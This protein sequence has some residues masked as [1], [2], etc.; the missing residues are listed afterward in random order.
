MKPI[1]IVGAGIAGLSAA[2]VLAE[3]GI[4][5]VVFDKSRAVGGRMATR[6]GDD[7][8]FDHGAQYF[9][10][11]THEFRDEIAAWERAGVAAAWAEDRFVGV[12]DM[13]APARALS[14]GLSVVFN[15]TVSALKRADGAWALDALEGLVAQ[16][17]GG[18][19]G[20]VLAMPAPQVA[21]VLAA[22]GLELPGVE[23]ATYAPCWALMVACETPIAGLESTLRPASDMIAWVATN[24]AKP[25]RASTPA[26][27]V[28][29]ARAAWTQ[30]NLELD[31]EAARDALLA[32]F[33]AVTGATL[34]GC[35][36]MAHRWRYALVE[37]AVGQPFLFDAQAGVGACGDWC[38]G[39]RV[40][41]AWLS[42][43]AMG[44]RLVI[45]A[46]V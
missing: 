16:P 18:F 20:V 14:N 10:A 7:S 38:L 13:P 33:T 2:R 21:N 28:V 45:D 35:S 40:E 37:R 36:A 17:E 30:A 22:S 8:A 34:A 12:P 27:Y 4:P 6:R 9:K 31:R 15:C 5:V 1:A 23:T 42:G 24:S 39:P 3:A 32:E 26:C 43:R 11:T 29:H 25:Q 46:S 19:G 41:D 44:H